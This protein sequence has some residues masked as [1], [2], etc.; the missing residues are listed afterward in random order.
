MFC[1]PAE[2][3]RVSRA[4]HRRGDA[5]ALDFSGGITLLEKTEADRSP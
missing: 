5:D 2:S 1:S 4:G 3:D